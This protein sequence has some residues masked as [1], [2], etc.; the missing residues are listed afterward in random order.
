MTQDRAN[1]SGTEAPRPVEGQSNVPDQYA[2][3]VQTED[4]L[5]KGTT[6][7]VT[8]TAT[9]D[10]HLQIPNESSH[11]LGP[12]ATSAPSTRPPSINA[13]YPPT[14]VVYTDLDLSIPPPLNYSLRPRKKYIFWFWFLVVLDVV[15][16]P[17]ALYFGLWYGTSL[18]P[19]AVFS[20][21][22]ALLGTVSI[23]EYF[24]RFYRLW[25]KGSTCRVIGAK[26]FY[27]DFFHWNLS[28]AW[29]AVM[30]ELIVGTV[31]E[32]PPIR[33]LAMPVSSMIFGIAVQFLL[34]D[35][36]RLA[37]VKAPVRVSSLPRG[38]PLRPGIY[39]IIEDIVAVDGSGGTEFR[40]RLNLRYQASH[41]FRQ[42]LHRLT[43][44]WAFGAFGVA[45]ATTAIIFTIDGDIAYILGWV[46]PFIWAG[47]W[48]WITIIWVQRDLEKERR[49]WPK[50]QANP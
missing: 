49:E 12:T 41:L 38:V 44:F 10:T 11:A 23:V 17:I 6:Q 40:Q 30:I 48:S 9:N 28:I 45:S 33:L 8:T 46:I 18:S 21:S 24:L 31:Q 13:M 37:G 47:I 22:T 1:T 32:N 26:R 15:C 7:P 50:E 39:S 29:I 16:M 25:K 36:L 3:K 20:I 43:L 42:M 34:I 14:Q 27:L 5:P 4:H 35:I 19:N 2:E